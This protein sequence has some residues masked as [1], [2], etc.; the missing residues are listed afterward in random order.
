MADG[1]RM[2][3]R[4]LHTSDVH[5]LSLGDRACHSLNAV[6]EAAVKTEVDLVVVAG[7]LFDSNRV[8]DELASFAAEQLRHLAASALALS[9][10]TRRLTSSCPGTL[11]SISRV[12]IF[13]LSLIGSF[14]G[15]SVQ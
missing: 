3:R 10:S 7:D 8:D 14:S 5:L 2:R 6:V 12:G 15:T 9:S 1:S 13:N 11:L 4:I